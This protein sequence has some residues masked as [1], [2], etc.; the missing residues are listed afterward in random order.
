[1][2]MYIKKLNINLF[3]NSGFENCFE[4]LNSQNSYYSRFCQQVGSYIEYLVV[5]F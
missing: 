2:Y 4:N 5:D 1:M 3:F